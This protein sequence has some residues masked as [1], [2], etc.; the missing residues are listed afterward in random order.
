MNKKATI[1][2][3]IL[4]NSSLIITI[5]GLF[6]L[7]LI[8]ISIFVEA[9]PGFKAYGWSILGIKYNLPNGQAGIILP[10]LTSFIIVSLSVLI[11]TFIGIKVAFFLKFRS[12][13]WFYK[14]S[15]FLI[16]IFS[17]MP[18]VLIG[19]FA[20]LSL[21][22]LLELLN[23]ATTLNVVT[24]ILMLAIMTLPTIINFLLLS[25]ET[26]E[27]SLLESALSLGLSKTRAIYKIIKAKYREN[28]FATVMF[29]FAKALGE[30]MALNFILTSQ[31]YNN[32]YGSGFSAFW[33]SGLKT[34]ASLI[35]YNAFAENGTEAFRG[36]LFTYALI[37]FAL[38][39]LFN[40][41]SLMILKPTKIHK[42][43]KQKEIENKAIDD[44]KMLNDNQWKFNNNY[45][46]EKA[47][48]RYKK[49]GEWIS[50]SVFYIVIFWVFG[51]IILNG[52][53]ALATTGSTLFDFSAN[54]TGRAF[55]N[56]L[57][58]L[59][60]S[61]A[62]ILP[63]T[64]FSAI[65]IN[66]YLK[67]KKIKNFILF[68]LDSF[69]ATPSIIFGLFG[70]NFF[71]NTLKV[72]GTGFNNNSLIAGILTLLLLIYAPLTRAFQQ[73]LNLPKKELWENALALNITK[74]KYLFKIL[75]PSIAFSMLFAFFNNIN[76][77]IVEAAPLFLTAGLSSSSR[78]GLNLWGQTLTTRIYAQL[79]SNSAQAQ[80]IMYEV[81]FITFI[82]IILLTVFIRIVLPR[83]KKLVNAKKGVKYAK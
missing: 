5:F 43:A 73:N 24:A 31:S 13:N 3:S 70:Y 28:I 53:K 33:L 52:L 26:L 14:C 64:F 77:V 54:S 19:V 48:D 57:V 45:Y 69:Q 15:K 2:N 65:Y 81:A 41:V 30:S 56:T 29:A 4:K 80:N 76:K 83:I 72:S 7:F 67:N 42:K 75:I 71:V 25:L 21:S 39:M 35:S 44:V 58:I 49:I 55:V 6:I 51:F 68:T 50:I 34:I 12:P 59:L 74:Q 78:F 16:D 18:S 1:K 27:P 40:S 17:V 37:L 63:F 10:L 36:I 22:K 8:L 46:I 82:F 9:L 38:V 32:V 23:F 79:F 47:Y 62:I 11:A 66:E 61:L 20:S 60:L